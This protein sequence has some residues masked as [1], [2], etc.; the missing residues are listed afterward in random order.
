MKKV[1]TRA[2]PGRSLVFNICNCTFALNLPILNGKARVSIFDEPDNIFT[3]TL[4]RRRPSG[5]KTLGSARLAT[6]SR[7]WS[8]GWGYGQSQM[9]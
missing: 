2:T 3:L 1:I 4:R 6:E 8:K 5:G 9:C 7:R